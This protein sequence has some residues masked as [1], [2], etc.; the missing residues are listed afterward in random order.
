[1]RVRNAV[2][3]SLTGLMLTT[4][5]ASMASAQVIYREVQPTRR[6]YVSE[7]RWQVRQ[8][9]A[10]AYRD[11]LRREPDASGLRQYT[12]AMLNEGWSERDVRRSLANS[13]EYQERFGRVGYWR[14]RR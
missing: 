13:R 6:Y 8:V 7:S 9:V 5:A 10:Q 4:G 12:N 14:Y 1:M 11:I 3:T 2:L